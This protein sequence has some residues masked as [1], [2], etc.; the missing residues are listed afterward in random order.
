MAKLTNLQ[1][2]WS[3]GR[4]FLACD[5]PIVKKKLDN[6][7]CEVDQVSR[8]R[9]LATAQ[10]E[11]GAWLNVLLVSSQLGHYWTRRSL[12]LPL[13]ADVCIPH[14]FSYGGRMDSRGLHGLSCKYSAGCF[15]RHSAKNDVIKRVLRKAGQPSILESPGLDIGDGSRP[16]DKIIFP[17]SS[18]SSMVWVC[19]CIDNFAGVHLNRSAMEAGTA[20]NCA[21]ERKR[22]K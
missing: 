18:G 21:E 10:K 6:M 14:C 8:A 20:A 15:A 12:R 1:W 9:L 4:C 22:S 2:L 7:L 11:R 17:F 5:L 13:P 19:T 3:L 16:D